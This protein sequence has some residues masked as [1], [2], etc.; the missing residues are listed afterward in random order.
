MGCL[1]SCQ[2]SDT[3]LQTLACQAAVPVQE[4]MAVLQMLA[5]AQQHPACWVHAVITCNMY[6]SLHTGPG[7]RAQERVNPAS[8][9]QRSAPSPCKLLHTKSQLALLH[10]PTALTLLAGPGPNVHPTPLT[11][12]SDQMTW[13]VG[14]WSRACC[15]SWTCAMCWRC[16]IQGTGPTSTWCR[17]PRRLSCIASPTAPEAGLVGFWPCCR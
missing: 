11:P 15:G 7:H 2:A 4:M 13:R 12:T 5:F 8:T 14:P 10:C 9:I 1:N 6:T 3:L 17:L 16:V